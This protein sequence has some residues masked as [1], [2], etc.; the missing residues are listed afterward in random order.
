MMALLLVLIVT[1]FSMYV[2]CS[3]NIGNITWL[4][5]YQGCVVGFLISGIILQISNKWRRL[6]EIEKTTQSFFN[7]VRNWN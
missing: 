4:D 1:V 6:K 2:S 3:M 7:L 5:Y